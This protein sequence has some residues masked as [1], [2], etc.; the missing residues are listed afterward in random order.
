MDWI[1]Q[2]RFLKKING[3]QPFFAQ[4]GWSS[5]D[6][7]QVPNG[8]TVW[9]TSGKVINPDKSITLKWENNQ[10]IKFFQKIS[11]DDNFMIKV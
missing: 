2:R 8:N 5:P 3:E 1:M 6:D 9:E 7:I 10:G 4:F 11:I